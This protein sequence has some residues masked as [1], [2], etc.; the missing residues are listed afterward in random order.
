MILSLKL[1]PR[2]DQLPGRGLT[3]F[4]SLRAAQRA[5]SKHIVSLLGELRRSIQVH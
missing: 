4:T 1:A 3:G 2:T 5:V